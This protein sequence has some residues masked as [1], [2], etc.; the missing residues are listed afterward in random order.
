MESSEDIVI[1]SSIVETNVLME[2]GDRQDWKVNAFGL[3]TDLE[4]S[5]KSCISEYGLESEEGTFFEISFFPDDF[6]KTM[7]EAEERIKKR[8]VD[9]L[10]FPIRHRK[11]GTTFSILF[12]MGKKEWEAIASEGVFNGFVERMSAELV[13][14]TNRF[15][16]NY[17]L[18][19]GDS[20]IKN[21]G[22]ENC[23][24]FFL[25]VDNKGRQLVTIANSP[26]MSRSIFWDEKKQEKLDELLIQEI[27]PDYSLDR[28]LLDSLSLK[29]E[30]NLTVSYIT[31]VMGLEIVVFEYFRKRLTEI[32]Q[33][34]EQAE[35]KFKRARLS[36]LLQM[37]R[38]HQV[39]NDPE[40]KY[41]DQKYLENIGNA[42]LVRNDIVHRGKK[43]QEDVLFNYWVDVMNFIKYFSSKMPNI[44]FD[45]KNYDRTKFIEPKER[46]VVEL[47][48][49][50][51]KVLS[52]APEGS[53]AFGSLMPD[54]INERISEA[55]EKDIFPWIVA[56]YLFSLLPEQPM[57]L[58][59]YHLEKSGVFKPILAFEHL[60][61]S[62]D[63]PWEISSNLGKKKN[64]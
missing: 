9:N 6:L 59:I 49:H 60:D 41:F 30:G 50:W 44:Y 10:M 31:L 56:E 29:N 27:E 8:H 19:S 52:G 55:V 35:K 47:A 37:D 57:T 39:L 21:I 14:T 18:V 32:G 4:I 26:N 61:G 7:K 53:Y 1:I 2:I 12:H 33:F 54:M 28:V 23:H 22:E 40:K 42:Y 24:S 62:W 58:S 36:D 45:P 5:N 43:I 25:V 15:I 34:G 51:N 38:F 20:Y 11:M 16:N 48:G 46:L 13:R 64:E 63:S 17:R 3:L